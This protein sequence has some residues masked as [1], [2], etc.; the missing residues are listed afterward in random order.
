MKPILFSIHGMKRAGDWQEGA[1]AI[2]SPH[3]D[4]RP[5]HYSE[6]RRIGILKLSGDLIFL[7]IAAV[8]LYRCHRV[9][10]LTLPAHLCVCILGV[11]AI[12]G[13]IHRSQRSRM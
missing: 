6:Y 2:L 11:L 9:H 7:L 4:Y 12:A 13:L 5:I 1:A 8:T 10:W 3:F